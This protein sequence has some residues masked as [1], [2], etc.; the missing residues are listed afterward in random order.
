[1][2]CSGTWED[3]AIS[4][5]RA[6]IVVACSWRRAVQAS[7]RSGGTASVSWRSVALASPTMPT[8]TGTRLRPIS[9]G[10]TSTWM[11]CVRFGKRPYPKK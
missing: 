5:C 10:L 6:A 8:L 2:G 11:R 7:V 4:A 3:C 1:M 9:S